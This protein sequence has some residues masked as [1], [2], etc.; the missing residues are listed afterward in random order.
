MKISLQQLFSFS[1]HPIANP[2]G[3]YMAQIHRFHWRPLKGHHSFRTSSGIGSVLCYEC[4]SVFLFSLLTANFSTAFKMLL[5]AILSEVPAQTFQGLGMSPGE[6]HLWHL[7]FMQT[8]IPTFSTPPPHRLISC[9]EYCKNFLTGF[10]THG[11]PPPTAFYN[12]STQL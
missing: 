10:C 9:L 2:V 4:I 1:L 3:G 11:P 6:S 12:W 7:F 5:K 8:A